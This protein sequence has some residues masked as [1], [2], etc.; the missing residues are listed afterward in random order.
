VSKDDALVVVIGAGIVG[1]CSALRIAR[2]GR[3]V[4]LVDRLEPGSAC[5][6]GNAGAI[7]TSA[8][9]P[10]ALPGML[11]K[12]PQWLADPLGPLSVRWSYLPR[13]APWLLRW[14]A[15]S[16]R[17][18]VEVASAALA[19]L[20]RT[21]IDGY[22]ELLTAGR[23][24]DLIRTTGHLYVWKRRPNGP[25]D[26]LAQSLRERH[27]IRTEWLGAGELRELEPDLSSRY[28]CG[29]LL[30]D[31]AFTVNPHRLVASL[32][33]DFVALGGRVL[34][35]EVVHLE[36]VGD[37]RVIVRT[38][39]ASFRAADVVVSGG[40][41]SN[42]LLRPLGCAVPLET[43]RG[44]HL[45]L[46]APSVMPKLPIM[47]AERKFFATPM[48]HGLRLAGTVEIG[49]LTAA[50]DW[51]RAEI[52]LAQATEAFPGLTARGSS[53]W[54][55][56][57]PSMPDSVPVIS[58]LDRVPRVVV[59][60]GHGHLGMSGAPGTSRLV[61]DLTLGRTPFIDPRPYRHGRFWARGG[62][63]DVPASP[64]A[65]PRVR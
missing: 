5:S 38:R 24:A 13:A 60:F 8:L 62:A 26:V 30:P 56:M 28:G 44:Y 46:E 10:M 14:L 32:I 33:D 16:R 54:M 37:S 43:E 12:V 34:R 2:E 25:G 40:A 48:E 9:V 18:R 57:R 64:E 41:W 63:V 53:V 59:A 17:E 20:N 19:A 52:L 7:S 55:G 58:T 49:G 42:Q 11:A 4:L 39:T 45:M 51:R 47:I 3:N 61:T 50:P 29:M 22:R 35:D 1:T 27:G 21:A 36:S 65:E 31:N 23:F 6:F 15:E